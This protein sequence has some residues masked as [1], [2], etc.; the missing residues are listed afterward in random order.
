MKPTEDFFFDLREEV[1][2]SFRFFI[3]KFLEDEVVGGDAGAE[4]LG[5]SSDTETD[6]E[7]ILGPEF[8]DDVLN[9]DMSRGA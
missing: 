5:R 7:D 6:T 1:G 4:N 9:A 2:N 8:I 3:G